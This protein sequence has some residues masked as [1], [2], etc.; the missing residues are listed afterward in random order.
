MCDI[1][2][3]HLYGPNYT[4]FQ[5]KR[6][7]YLDVK[8]Y[9]ITLSLCGQKHKSELK[10]NVTLLINTISY[11]V[12]YLIKHIIYMIHK[13]TTHALGVLRQALQLDIAF[14][15]TFLIQYYQL[16]KKSIR[17]IQGM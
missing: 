10:I 4:D 15:R 11:Y 3:V 6:C 12:T 2:H 16:Q 17:T 8:Q 5:H 13:I 14:L 7:T 1:K 9:G